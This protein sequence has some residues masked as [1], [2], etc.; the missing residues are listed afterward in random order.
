MT[1]DHQYPKPLPCP[2]CGGVELTPS[3]EK[4]WVYVCCRWCTAT[5]PRLAA[6]GDI[7]DSIV[8][9]TEVWNRRTAP[10]GELTEAQITEMANASGIIAGS[11]PDSWHTG[12]YVHHWRLAKFASLVIAAIADAERGKP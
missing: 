9:A 11:P 2:F 6:K 7:A 5:G 8:R 10:G 4:G 1:T 12:T 3:F